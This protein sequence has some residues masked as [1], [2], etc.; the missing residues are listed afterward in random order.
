MNKYVWRTSLVWMLLI[1]GVA[2]VLLY[3]HRAVTSAKAKSHEIE[4][5]AEGP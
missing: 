3:R 1:A 5:V 2:G 4:P